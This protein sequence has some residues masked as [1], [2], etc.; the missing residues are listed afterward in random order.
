MATSADGFQNALHITARVQSGNK[1]EI[2]AP[3]CK[4]AR[5]STSSWCPV[6]QRRDR[7]APCSNSWTL[8][9]QDHGVRTR[10]TRSSGGSR[11]NATHGIVEGV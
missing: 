1:I 8:C 6:P 2:I 5:T 7:V 4:R 11:R 3:G 9:P 10:G